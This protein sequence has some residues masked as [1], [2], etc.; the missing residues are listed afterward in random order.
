MKKL[1]MKDETK[2]SIVAA[3]C[4][5]ALA[6]IFKN[7]L[8]IPY[9]KTFILMFS[10]VILFVVYWCSKDSKCKCNTTNIWMAM[11]VI[12]TIAIIALYAI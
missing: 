11:I 5:M 7:V 2:V 4:V 9:D 6:V 12:V 8:H 1:K 10:P 3:I